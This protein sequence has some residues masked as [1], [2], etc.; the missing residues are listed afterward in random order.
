MTE[1]GGKAVVLL[2][3]AVGGLLSLVG[4]A[5]T[6]TSEVVDFVKMELESPFPGIQ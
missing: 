3:P 4:A 2:F 6:V 5:E 1:A